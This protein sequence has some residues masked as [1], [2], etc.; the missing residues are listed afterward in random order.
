[1]EASGRGAATTLEIAHPHAEASG[2]VGVQ[3]WPV[4]REMGW[5]VAFWFVSERDAT[6][7]VAAAG[8]RGGRWEVV[9]LERRGGRRG[10]KRTEDAETIARAGSWIYVLGSQ[11][12]PK[13]GPLEHERHFVARFNEALVSPRRAR[14]VADV[15]VARRP[16]LL[17]RI[18]NDALREAGVKVLADPE[19]RERFVVRARERGARKGKRWSRLL[20]GDDVPVNVEGAA[21]LPGGHLLLGLRFPTTADGHPILIELEGIDRYLDAPRVP[22]EVVAVRVLRSIGSRRAPAGVRG[23]DVLG[24]E[25]HLLTGDLDS[26]PEKSAVL[27]RHPRAA[28]A[29]SAH[30]AAPLAAG[31][32]APQELPARRV[33]AFGDGPPVEGLATHRGAIWYAHDDEVVRLSA[34]PVERDGA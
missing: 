16:F 10:T 2:L 15:E 8:R 24:S 23:L 31:A 6:R 5:D 1:M 34:A 13:R 14:L 11:F 19:L 29:A 27:A 12:G 4:L 25:I 26:K 18:V 9:R 17:H 32:H 30:W 33:R 28:R 20:R 21:F 3:S 7:A 22:P